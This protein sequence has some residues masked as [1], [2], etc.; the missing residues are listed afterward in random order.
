M[1]LKFC[2][3]QDIKQD[4]Q[5]E[6]HQ[7]MAAAGQRSSAAVPEMHQISNFKKLA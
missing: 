1:P 4:T 2:H 6:A 7:D 3:I 5:F